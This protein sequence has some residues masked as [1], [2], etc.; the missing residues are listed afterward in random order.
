MRGL[1]NQFYILGIK[2]EFLLLYFERHY[3]HV[4]AALYV[5]IC[6]CS[7]PQPVIAP[8]DMHTAVVQLHGNGKQKKKTLAQ[9]LMLK[10]C[11]R[12][13]NIPP[14]SHFHIDLAVSRLF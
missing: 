4:Q 6:I 1:Q 11:Y 10:V 13:N 7:V 3:Q 2:N 14:S 9:T 12:V 8:A 5:N